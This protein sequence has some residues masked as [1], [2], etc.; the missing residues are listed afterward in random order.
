MICSRKY[1]IKINTFHKIF[2]ITFD[3]TILFIFK[4]K[5]YILVRGSKVLIIDWLYI[6]MNEG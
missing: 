2:M 6:M 5:I 1:R 3:T 4:L